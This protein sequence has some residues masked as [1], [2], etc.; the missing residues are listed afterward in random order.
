MK[1][2]LRYYGDPIL[3]TPC[4]K[5][6][7][8][9]EEI[10]K[11]ALDMIETMVASDNTVGLAANQVG[12]LHKILVIRP[13]IKMPN[14]QYT[15]GPP[16]VYIN[17]VISNPSEETEIMCEGCLSFPGLHV[18]VERP[19]SIHVDALDINGKP[20]S[21]DLFGFKAREVMHE[22]DHLNG[23][24]FIDRVSK[25]ARKRIEPALREIKKKYS[26]HS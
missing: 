1:L 21:V 15:L 8:V 10:K 13:E 23:K 24:V 5:V 16:E 19:I 7:A 6:E 14:G 17:P 2:P 20:F 18:E 11:I 22:N 9:T 4:K 12:F 26:K 25:E 3:R